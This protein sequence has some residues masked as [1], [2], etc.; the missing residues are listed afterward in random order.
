MDITIN[1]QIPEGKTNNTKRTDIPN[2]IV[3]DF[4]TPLSVTDKSS[5]FQNQ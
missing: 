2:T 1:H 3:R 5:R 4:S